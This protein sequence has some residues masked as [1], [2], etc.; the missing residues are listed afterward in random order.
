[1]TEDNQKVGCQHTKILDSSG[2][3]LFEKCK[4]RKDDY[5]SGRPKSGSKYIVM[6]PNKNPLFLVISLSILYGLRK[7]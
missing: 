3:P 5:N 7:I 2:L 6:K 1:L 4:N